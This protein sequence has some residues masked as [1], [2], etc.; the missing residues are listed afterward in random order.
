MLDISYDN[1]S[2]ARFGGFVSFVDKLKA[3]TIETIVA[4]RRMNGAIMIITGDALMVG[5]A[6]GQKPRW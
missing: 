4:A 5:E 6:V 3:T 1:G 2:G